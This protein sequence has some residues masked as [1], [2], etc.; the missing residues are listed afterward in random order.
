[1]ANCAKCDG[2]SFRLID[3]AQARIRRVREDLAVN[4][5]SP[6]VLDDLDVD[7]L[8]C[9]QFET[10]FYGYTPGFEEDLTRVSDPSGDLSS[11]GLMPMDL[12]AGQFDRTPPN[13][14]VIEEF[15]PLWACPANRTPQRPYSDFRAL[16]PEHEQHLPY[17]RQHPRPAHVSN[18]P[19]VDVEVYPND[20]PSPSQYEY[21]GM[22]TYF[23]ARH[24]RS[25]FGYMSRVPNLP[26]IPE[27]RHE[28]HNM[29][30][31]TLNRSNVDRD[32]I[33]DTELIVQGV[34]LRL[35]CILK[36]HTGRGINDLN[37][38]SRNREADEE[39]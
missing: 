13:R 5:Q 19:L 12:S 33:R 6:R 34:I 16:V 1:M 15:D 9:G 29:S 32:V 30:P 36:R 25:D 3:E 37:L 23:E 10:S 8:D 22:P 26:V 14:S 11:L 27:E 7:N 2:E 21:Y 31:V 18:Q 20:P 39:E 24:Q 38:W 35:D 28:R 4:Y 17:S